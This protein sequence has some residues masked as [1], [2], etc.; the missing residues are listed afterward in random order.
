MNTLALLFG[1]VLGLVLAA[2]IN[3]A[4]VAFRRRGKSGA[5]GR[6][7]V[8]CRCAVDCPHW[9]GNGLLEVA[10]K[11]R[12]VFQN[13]AAALLLADAARHEFR[14]RERPPGTK[15]PS[16]ADIAEGKGV[17]DPEWEKWQA[18]FEV[19]EVKR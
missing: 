11:S 4:P 13:R 6:Y 8:K 12:L 16:I 17:F 3:T 9:V 1:I 19:V 2:L 7:A 14:E 5:I 15:L 18:R 10:E